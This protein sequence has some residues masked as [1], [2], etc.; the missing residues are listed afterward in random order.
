M[1]RPHHDWTSHGADSFRYL[2]VSIKDGK[3]NQMRPT[4]AI[5]E[6]DVLSSNGRATR[7]SDVDEYWPW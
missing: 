4:M 1:Q 7:A 2:S 3:R 6:Y 5:T